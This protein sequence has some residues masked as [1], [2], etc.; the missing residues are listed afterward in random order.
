[1]AT[2]DQVVESAEDEA[3]D[4]GESESATE[5][6]AE[7]GREVSVL[8]LCEA[9]LAASRNLPELRRT[10]RD[11]A[12][13]LVAVLAF[14]TAFSFANVA[15]FEALT[16]WFSRSVAALV[17]GAAWLVVGIALALALTVRA[18]RVTGWH[19]WRVFGG[20]AEA[21]TDDLERARD[22]AEAA[23]RTTLERLA[24]AISV[25]LAAAVLPMAGGAVTGVMDMGDDVLDATEDMVEDLTESLPGGGVVSQMWSIVLVP[26]RLGLRVATTVLAAARPSSDSSSA[27]R[28]GT[29]ES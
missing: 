13:A 11:I 1:M 10:A 28:G 29:P 19:W 7:L 24:P 26:G 12:A 5:L 20:G 22:E 2:V 17:L 16:A 23:V 15:A 3:A 8:V 4:E 9:Q 6:L 14:L 27:E 25:E 21:A 18:G